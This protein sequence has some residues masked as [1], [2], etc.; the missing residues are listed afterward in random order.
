VRAGDR[1]FF[2][3]LGAAIFTIAAFWVIFGD[4]FATELAL[5][6]WWAWASMAFA[7]AT[8]SVWRLNEWQKDHNLPWYLRKTNFDHWDWRRGMVM[9]CGVVL[10]NTLDAFVLRPWLR[11]DNGI[12]SRF[13]ALAGPLAMAALIAYVDLRIVKSQLPLNEQKDQ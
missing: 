7:A 12:A 2:T 9:A 1:L 3:A 10:G 13:F 6:P 4:E 5:I 11:S 8:I